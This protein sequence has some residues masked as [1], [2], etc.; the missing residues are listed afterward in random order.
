MKKEQW[1]LEGDSDYIFEKYDDLNFILL[2]NYD[3]KILGKIGLPIKVYKLI[4]S[5][6]WNWKNFQNHT[7]N[8]FH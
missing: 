7:T 1:I 4:F 3:K 5:I 6:S 2:C 8:F